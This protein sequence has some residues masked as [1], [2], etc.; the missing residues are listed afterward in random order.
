M[1]L[2]PSDRP[3]PPCFAEW[4][5]LGWVILVRDVVTGPLFQLRFQAVLGTALAV[6]HCVAQM[7]PF[8]LV[9]LL[10]MPH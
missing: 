3:F 7:R 1:L 6:K 4:G 5:L 8:A 2:S 10:E 9:T